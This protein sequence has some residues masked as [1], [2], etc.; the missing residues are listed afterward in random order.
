[1]NPLKPA[2]E[3][4]DAIVFPFKAAAIL[5]MCAA[6]N[7]MTA[8]QHLWVK[9]V[10]LGLGIALIVKIARAIKVLIVA[11]VLAA[12]AVATWQWWKKRNGAAA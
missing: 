12:L 2:K 8:P 6:I 1:M 3:V 9:W 5:A 7:W 10:A 11:G 4:L